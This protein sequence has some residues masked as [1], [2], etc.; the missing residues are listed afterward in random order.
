MYVY[1]RVC[2][3]VFMPACMYLSVCVCVLVCVCMCVLWAAGCELYVIPYEI[4]KPSEFI[5]I[6]LD[7]WPDLWL[8]LA[9]WR[10]VH[11][12]LFHLCNAVHGAGGA[13]AS[14]LK[15]PTT[16]HAMAALH[17][18]EAPSLHMRSIVVLS[19]RAPLIQ[20]FL[21]LIQHFCNVYGFSDHFS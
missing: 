5:Q 3:R 20:L 14:N 6:Q 15:R 19:Q 4:P 17:N 18:F 21:K 9:F 13:R 12:P 2:V 7:I 11:V 10:L 1:T 8:D 16:L